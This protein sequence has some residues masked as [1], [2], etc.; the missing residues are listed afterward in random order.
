[1]STATVGSDTKRVYLF[2]EGAKELKDLLGG[3]GANLAEMTKMGFPVPQGFTITTKTCIEYQ[4]TGK[5]P[6]GLDAEV[7]NGM[8]YI[9]DQMGM[10]FG[11]AENPLL[12]SVRSGAKISMPGMMDT[13][14]NLGLNDTTVEGLIKKTDNPRFAYD[15]YRRFIMMFGDV[16]TGVSKNKFDEVFKKRRNELGY[17]FDYE[18]PAEDL[19]KVVEDFKQIYKKALG[20]DFP[21][22]VNVQL[23]MA[24]EAVFK[25]WNNDRAIIY[26][27]REGIPHDLGTAVNVQ[28]M[29]YGNM[30]ENSGT[31]V[32]F[33]RSSQDGT[34]GITGDF[35]I[36]AQ[37]EDV[38]AGVRN[39]QPITD[40][41]KSHPEL[42][43]QL[44]Q[45]CKKLELH[46]KDMQDMEFTIQEGKLYMLQTRNGKRSPIAAIRIA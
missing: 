30:G 20:Q 1:M 9:E 12:V 14:L 21:E 18:V 41:Q 23:K 42:Y 29:V 10:K 44:E 46:Y 26:R 25:S 43:E 33:T 28:A 36:N 16:V 31:G 24:V 8:K 2:N 38:V 13:V 17:K 40:M 37:G 3:K 39:T 19:K 15:A 27:D 7:E 5:L 4:Q 11:D 22:D 35:L 32:C 6:D 45:I 34:K